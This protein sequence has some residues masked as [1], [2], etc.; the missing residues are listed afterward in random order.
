MSLI[1]EGGMAITMTKGAAPIPEAR[2]LVS[3]GRILD[4][5]KADEVELLQMAGLK[6]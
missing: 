5:G 4:I 2:V 6:S 1:V 3:R